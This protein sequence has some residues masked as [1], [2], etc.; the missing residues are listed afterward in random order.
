VVE[1][2]AVLQ[3]TS[4]TRIV[5]DAL[6]AT[7]SNPVKPTMNSKLKHPVLSILAKLPI[8][9]LRLT[10]PSGEIL[11]FGDSTGSHPMIQADINI[12]DL[13]VLGAVSKSG[14]IGLAESYMA[15]H[16]SSPDVARLMRLL[17]ANREALE[18]MIYGSWWGSLLYRIQHAFK[19][20]S[21]SGSQKNIHAHYDIGNDFYRLWLD[22]DMSYSS[23]MFSQIEAANS[24]DGMEGADGQLLGKA[25]SVKMSRALAQIGASKGVR[26]AEI[27]CGWGALAHMAVLEFGAQIDGITLSDE[28]LAWG[29]A[30]MQRAQI[31]QQAQLMRLDYRDLPARAKAQPYDA[32]VS[33]EMFEA[34]GKQYWPDFFNAVF[35]SLKKGGKA[36][37][38]TITIRDDL[39]AKYERG[40]DFIQQ[41]IFPGGF[42][43]SD[44]EFKKAAQAAGLV[45]EEAFAFG[46]DYARTL[47]VWR[48]NFMAQESAVRGLGFD[49]RFIRLW[50]FYLAYCEAAFSEGSTNVVQYTLR[51]P[52]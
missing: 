46:Q 51:R 35:E 31:D 12:H 8:G 14:D 10:L 44:A 9:H 20:N 43:P 26:I 32:V 52:A 30:R 6:G 29:V 47:A 21:R 50:E 36:C 49:T 38:Q 4:R 40:T 5:C 19:R 22:E 42:L 3:I 18:R 24:D 41:Y 15:G 37:I 45:V 2:R 13:A 17:I 39:F 28:Q 25:H 16:W 11:S 34:V 33:I 23:A 27:G 1:E 7:K 48:S